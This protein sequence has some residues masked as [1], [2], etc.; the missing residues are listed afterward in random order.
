MHISST[1]GANEVIVMPCR[2]HNEDDKDY[3]VVFAT[4]LNAKGITIIVSEP[5]MRATGEAAAWDYPVTAAYG[6]GTSEC[7]IVFDDVFVPWERVFLC[8]EWEFSRDITYAFA[9]FHRL[10]GVCR[11]TTELEMLAGVSAL[12]AEYNGIERY[13]HIRDK[14]A[15]LAMYA[16]A[17]NII[18]KSSCIYCEK[19]ADSDLVSPN[20]VYTNT[21]KFL[22]ADNYHQ[23]TKTAH[24][25]C[26]GIADTIPSHRDWSN[27]ETRPWL[28]MVVV[29]G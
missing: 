28:E 13:P 10:F 18:G 23:A 16:E 25:I 2:A 26:G 5:P 27:P 29:A 22:F 11:M 1:P 7:M 20:M 8:G 3:A 14:L 21:A 12:M 17:V 15:W 19:V 9:T 4:P 24:D 6:H